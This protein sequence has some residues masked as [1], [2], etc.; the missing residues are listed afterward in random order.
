MTGTQDAMY[1]QLTPVYG[2]MPNFTTQ[3]MLFL[4][5]AGEGFDGF[6]GNDARMAFYLSRGAVGFSLG[7]VENDFWSRIG[8]SPLSLAEFYIDARYSQSEVELPIVRLL[9]SSVFWVDS[10]DS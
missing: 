1:A 7:D 4:F 5:W 2:G 9:E 8:V 6:P 10:E 3:D